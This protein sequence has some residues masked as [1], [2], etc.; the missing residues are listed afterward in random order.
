MDYT[1][2]LNTLE[3][4]RKNIMKKMVYGI[5]I[6][7]VALLVGLLIGQSEGMMFGAV[8]G[9][10]IAVGF[11]ADAYTKY[12]KLFKNDVMPLIIAKTGLS[13]QY[14]YNDGVGQNT[15]MNSCLFKKPDRYHCEDLMYGTID[16]VQFMSS[17]VHMEERHVR[18]DSKGRRH[19]EYVTFFQGR[20]F[21]YD[22]NKEFN[23]IIQV[24]E[25]GLLQGLPW[26]INAEK[27]SMED[28][29]FNKKFKTY[30]TN[31]H[32]AFYVLTPTLMVNMKKLESRYPGRIY[33]SFI[34]S[35][36]HIAIYNNKNSFE[37]PLFSPVDDRF[38]DEQV[39]EINILRE[40]VNELKL[41]RRIFK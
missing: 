16:D 29:E 40:I 28:V 23:G 14:N 5:G 27:I 36:L 20:W 8:I 24:R 13:L 31:Q 10:V 19:V 34:G 2:M 12:R 4:K 33:F 32:D 7:L 17:D 9:L 11:V 6:I 37:P 41:N 26:G 38:I 3:A 39:Q 22:F 25:D 15:V 18:V 35:Q 1:E 21:V 30:A